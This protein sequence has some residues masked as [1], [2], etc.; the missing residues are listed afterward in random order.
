[1][2]FV[3]VAS[4]DLFY[5]IAK[6]KLRL[7]ERERCRGRWRGRCCYISR[8]HQSGL[9]YESWNKGL[10]SCWAKGVRGPMVRCQ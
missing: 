9:A 4:S 7:R 3:F 5:R 6:G 2:L 8:Y 10:A 1:M